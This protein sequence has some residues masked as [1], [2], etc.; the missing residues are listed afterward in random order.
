MKHSP[1]EPPVQPER[2]P[3]INS[4]SIAVANSPYHEQSGWRSIQEA[5]PLGVALR[6][7][8]II[9]RTIWRWP[10]TRCF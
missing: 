8:S 1:L 5:S 9:E 7:R 3:L 2:Y 10:E 6:E 4:G